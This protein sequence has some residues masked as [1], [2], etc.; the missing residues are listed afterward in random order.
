MLSDLSL[1]VLASLAITALSL[2][3]RLL[4]PN[5]LVRRK[6]RAPMALGALYPLAVFG[7]E[8]A[9]LDPAVAGAIRSLSHLG[10]ALAVI[11]FLVVVLANPLREDRLPTAVPNIL[12]DAIIAGAFVL[13]GTLLLREKF[14]TT[15]AVGAV[16]IGFALQDTLGNA[17]A[18]LAIQV[19]KPFRVGEWIRV[20]EYVGRVEE[21]TWR[22]TKLRTKDTNFVIV[23]NSMIAKEA[24]TN[25]SEPVGPTRVHVDVGVS[26]DATPD[27]VKDALR[28]ALLNAALVLRSPAPAVQL[29]E[30]AASSIVYRAY[31][32]VADFATDGPARDQVRAN[33]YY[34]LKR[35][36]IEIPYPVQVEMPREPAPRRAPALT[37][38]FTALLGRS[39]LFA[40]LDED[41]RA[42]LAELGEERLYTRGEAIIREG[43]PGGSMFLIA[44]G[45]AEVTVA[46]AHVRTLGAGD[47]FGEM[48]LLT[49]EERAATVVAS[50]PCRLMEITSDAF[51]RFVMAEPGVFDAMQPAVLARRTE[52]IAV[53]E[54]AAAHHVAPVPEQSFLAQV[55]RFLRI[56]G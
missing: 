22:A 19:E 8:Y 3:V 23:P 45:Q 30:F 51:R 40:P 17:F 7:L 9:T 53:R 1:S 34:T 49:G 12:Q 35:H 29:R 32:W 24:I 18:G 16:V 38:E 27:A 44:A 56:A 26:Y 43:E 4:T 41:E 54:E 47:F 31:F 52:L 33:I 39:A 20:G 55:R 11:S 15:S 25:F 42:A 2:A 10:L 46:G 13:V 28:E 21:I 6:L 36:G 37:A 5:R 50:Q 14:L 48:S